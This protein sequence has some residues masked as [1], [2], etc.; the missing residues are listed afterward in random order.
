MYP[1][2]EHPFYGIFIKNF[3]NGIITNGGTVYRA[4]I[5]GRGKNQ[6]EKIMKYLKFFYD[7]IK[8]VF[9]K[10][11]DLIYVHYIG[12]S[13]LPLLL[14]HKYIKK[15]LI[16]NAHGSDVFVNNK[17]GKYIQ[18]LVTPLIKKADAIVVPSSYFENI[19]YSKFDIDKNKIFVSPSGGIDTELFKPYHENKEVE[20]FVIGYVS[21]IDEGKGWDVLLHAVRSVLDEGTRNFKVLMIGGGS[22]EPQLLN[23]IQS[24]RLEKN[25]E[26]IGRVD[27]EELVHYYN[28][29][30]V[31]S[32]STT[33][34]E[35]LGLVGLEAM[36]CGVPVVGSDI[37]GVKGYIENKYNGELFEPGNA[38]ELTLC[39]KKFITMDKK[40]LEFYSTNA[41]TTAK[42]YDSK[43]VSNNLSKMLKE[44]IYKDD[45]VAK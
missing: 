33:L 35:S 41:L 30:D 27:H 18:K 26:Y 34:N 3:E 5:E 39:L 16:V 31:F 28:K 2:H 15:P 19:I 20:E 22:Q 21:R 6:F 45:N 1:S 32:F 29:M 13:L 7:V 42:Q 38:Y 17:I 8:L 24:L 25:V 14:V 43:I 12:H 37:G 4:V 36:A 10:E 9:T 11:Y 23:M 40:N 44:I